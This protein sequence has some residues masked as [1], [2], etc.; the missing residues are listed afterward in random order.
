MLTFCREFAAK[1]PK[2]CLKNVCSRSPRWLFPGAADVEVCTRRPLLLGRGI[3]EH[4]ESS[5]GSVDAFR[6]FPRRLIGKHVVKIPLKQKSSEES[7]PRSCL[8]ANNLE[9]ICREVGAT[10]GYSTYLKMR[11]A[12]FNTQLRQ[13]RQQ[14]HVSL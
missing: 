5:L 11:F 13:Q 1:S 2:I 12:D 4:S 10:C 3:G 8:H 7:Y 9:L 6:L 14:T